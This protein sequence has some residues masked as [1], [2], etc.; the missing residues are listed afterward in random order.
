MYV[1]VQVH[2]YHKWEKTSVL[3]Y[4]RLACWYPRMKSMSFF[5]NEYTIL[6]VVLPL[7]AL[8]VVILE[9]FNMR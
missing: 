4:F 6:F 5:D 9:S 7:L 2:V 3:E 1:H 8:Y